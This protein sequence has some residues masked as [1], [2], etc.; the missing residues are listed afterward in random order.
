MSYCNSLGGAS[1]QFIDSHSFKSRR[2]RQLS[3]EQ[4]VTGSER[5]ETVSS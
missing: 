2:I 5:H 1:L 3:V 4:M